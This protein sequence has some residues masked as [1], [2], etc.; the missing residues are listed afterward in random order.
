MQARQGDIDIFG[1]NFQWLV[2]AFID[3]NWVME[4]IGK[5][6]VIKQ[7]VVSSGYVFITHWPLGDFKEI[8]GK[9]FS[10]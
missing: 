1:L 6:W 3:F 2:I 4:V 7:Y 5:V 8:L 10:S 9:K